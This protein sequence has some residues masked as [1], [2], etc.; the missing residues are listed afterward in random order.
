VNFTLKELEVKGVYVIE[1]RVFEDERGFFMETFSEGGFRAL[2][3]DFHVVQENHSHSRHG[4]LRGLH[5][6]RGRLLR[7]SL[8]VL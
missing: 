6:Q 1:P 3:V 4:V 2:G 7:R 5:F 8:C